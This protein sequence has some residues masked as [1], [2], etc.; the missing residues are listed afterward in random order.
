VAAVLLGSIFYLNSRVR[1]PDAVIIGQLVHAA[2]VT[3]GRLSG[4]F[5]TEGQQV[6]AGTPLFEMDDPEMRAALAG[7]QTR[8]TTSEAEAAAAGSRLDEEQ[9]RLRLYGEIIPLQIKR[10]EAA[11]RQTEARLRTARSELG[12]VE[13]LFEDKIGSQADLERAQTDV[14]SFEAVREEQTGALELLKLN[15]SALVRGLYF[16]G[17]DI[18]GRTRELESLLAAGR[19]RVAEARQEVAHAQERVARLTVR[20]P[21]GGTV[22]AVPLKS[23][24]YAS[25]QL[26]PVAID[27]GRDHCAVAN[28]AADDAVKITPGARARVWIPTRNLELAGVVTQVGALPT[29][30]HQSGA[31][32]PVAGVVP[33]KLRLEGAPSDLPSGLRAVVRLHV[34]PFVKVRSL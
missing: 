12:R 30:S 10:T 27:T 23:G 24:E 19:D 31:S 17:K 4:V 15:Q 9:A 28:I 25:A 29:I 14:E 33:V 32:G 7:A 6:E 22:F 11:I 1:V 26:A 8:L 34:N 2:P 18:Q 5:V 16:D 3:P 13:R 21:A 20:A